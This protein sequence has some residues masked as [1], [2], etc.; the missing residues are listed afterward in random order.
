MMKFAFWRVPIVL[1]SLGLLS[2]LMNA[3]GVWAVGDVEHWA[4][5]VG[6]HRVLLAM[7]RFVVYGAT[8]TAWLSMRRRLIATEPAAATRL[9]R[10]EVATLIVV[11]LIEFAGILHAW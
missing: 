1:L 3:L 7:W 10:V 5:W 8:I 6:Q 4:R 11:A 2:F 9:L